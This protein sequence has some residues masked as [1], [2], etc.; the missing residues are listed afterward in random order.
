MARLPL[1]S[2][3]RNRRVSIFC[4]AWLDFVFH[5]SMTGLMKTHRN[6]IRQVL[7]RLSVLALTAA[8][9]ADNSWADDKSADSKSNVTGTWRWTFNIPN[10]DTIEPFVK[11]KQD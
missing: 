7:S 4:S 10:G 11:L 9:L 2:P 5:S 6:S 1:T 8:L 3:R